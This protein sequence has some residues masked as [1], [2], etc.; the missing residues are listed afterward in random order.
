MYMV[1][2]FHFPVLFSET[3]MPDSNARYPSYG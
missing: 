3:K 1:F 2:K